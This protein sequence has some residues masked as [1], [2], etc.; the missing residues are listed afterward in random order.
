MLNLAS[1]ILLAAILAA[2]VSTASAAPIGAFDCEVS[3]PVREEMLRT[4]Q[5]ARPRLTRL[6]KEGLAAGNPN[7]LYQLEEYTHPLIDAARDCGQRDT[8]DE[9]S[10]LYQ[11]AFERRTN[12]E[13]GKG[14]FSG[15][16]CS[17]PACPSW[18]SS[19]NAQPFEVILYSSQF[20]YGASALVN[21]VGLIP[22]DE[23]TPAMVAYM[24][25]APYIAATYVRWLES[26][27]DALYPKGVRAASLALQRSAHRVDDKQL[28]IAG[29][30]VELLRAC[31]RDHARL[32]VPNA[33]RLKLREYVDIFW[34][35]IE[36][37]TR[38]DREGQATF[39]EAWGGIA[40]SKCASHAGAEPPT[41]EQCKGVKTLSLDLGHFV[42]VPRVI[43]SFH[44]CRYASG[45][46]ILQG[47]SRQF[48][49]EVFNGDYD[50]PRFYSYFSGAG[51]RGWYN[52]SFDKHGR[53]RS[54]GWAPLA[55]SNKGPLYFSLARYNREIARISA[56]Y[57]T[58]NPE[59]LTATSESS[60][61]RVFYVLAVL[62][63][64]IGVDE[65]SAAN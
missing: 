57:L 59:K 1:V 18:P 30:I 40:R 22:A 65:I 33:V 39:D 28:Q 42:R 45:G 43:E 2:T 11:V 21:A 46:L 14:R 24:G 34:K 60:D 5:L 62:P 48:A 38:F 25:N 7:V 35:V 53:V 19:G 27:G 44:R 47:F 51:M 64:L 61:E 50:Q 55:L 29:G 15:W 8:L 6:V 32:H 3:E 52:R 26:R 58:A 31:E 56:A 36:S 20:L 12:I 41:A 23:R 13:R 37:R 4:W 10:V 17:G 54:N 9:L 16:A 63:G 49:G